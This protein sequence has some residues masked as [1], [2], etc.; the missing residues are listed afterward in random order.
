MQRA[1]AIRRKMTRLPA[2]SPVSIPVA[3]IKSAC[4]VLPGHSAGTSVKHRPTLVNTGTDGVGAYS[5]IDFNYSQGGHRTGGIRVY[6]NELTV[7]FKVDYVQAASNTA[8]FPNLTTYPQK[9]QHLA[10]Q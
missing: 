6:Q 10:Y 8:P 1:P 4:R 9:L 3:R 7:L 2:L 5:E